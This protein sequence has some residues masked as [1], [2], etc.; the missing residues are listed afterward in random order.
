MQ[1]FFEK[2]SLILFESEGAWAKSPKSLSTVVITL[3]GTPYLGSFCDF[4]LAYT[5]SNKRFR[6]EKWCLEDDPASFWG[7]KDCLFS[8]V[9]A[10]KFGI[11]RSILPGQNDMEAWSSWNSFVSPAILLR[12]I[13]SGWKKRYRAAVCYISRMMLT[14]WSWFGRY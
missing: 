6:S 2:T 13:S 8:G 12:I 14:K 7:G 11:V 9:F 5:P 4:W 10:C 3:L 1:V